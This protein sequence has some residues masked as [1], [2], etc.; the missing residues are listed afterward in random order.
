MESRVHYPS[1]RTCPP[2]ILRGLRAVDPLAELLYAHDGQW[3]LGVCRFSWPAYQ[4]AWQALDQ[5]ERTVTKLPYVHGTAEETFLELERRAL[6]NHQKREFNRLA[7]QG[8]RQIGVYAQHD[9]DQ[10]IVRDFEYRDFEHRVFAD[11]GLDLVL[12]TALAQGDE[13][14]LARIAKLR[15]AIHT[16]GV[17]AWRHIRGLKHFTSRQRQGAAVA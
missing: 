10:R 14:K 12:E 6:S 8:Y 16:H 9:P 4:S 3:I 17:S 1:P 7:L 2:D 13:H 11:L 5:L 15:D